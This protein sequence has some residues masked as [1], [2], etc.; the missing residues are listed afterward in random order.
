MHQKEDFVRYPTFPAAE[1]RKDELLR[2][3]V[4]QL[5]WDFL[6]HGS[7]VERIYGLKYLLLSSSFEMADRCAQVVALEPSRTRLAWKAVS[8]YSLP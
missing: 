5:Q 2:L 8:F 6:G 7:T 1:N 4:R 3:R